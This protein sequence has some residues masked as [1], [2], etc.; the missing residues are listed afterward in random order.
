M[1]V[2]TKRRLE[3]AASAVVAVLLLSG[4][5]RRVLP[6]AT[7]NSAGPEGHRINSLFWPV[8]W[9]AVGVF[10]LVEGVLVVA[11]V[12]FRQRPGRGIPTQV[13]GNR[14]LEITWTV[15]PAVLLAGI[16]VPTIMGIFSVAARPTGNVLD[17]TVTGH[18]WWW[19]VR[20]P[21]MGVTTANEL[22]IP[23]HRYVYV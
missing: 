22:H 19:E 9:I 2:R 23:V 3:L 15:I 17:I 1:T 7:L 6:Q 12:R 4:C 11:L 13:H 5:G 18:Q 21:G 10:V 20:Y 14:R 8:F 16:A